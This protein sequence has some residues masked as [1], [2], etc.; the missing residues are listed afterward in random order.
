MYLFSGHQ[1]PPN[2]IRPLDII[3]ERCSQR[4]WRTKTSVDLGAGVRLVV[5]ACH[6]MSAA[7]AKRYAKLITAKI[8]HQLI[9]DKGTQ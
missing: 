8:W 2:R 3:C 6:C 5:L 7:V 1:L 4:V 9:I